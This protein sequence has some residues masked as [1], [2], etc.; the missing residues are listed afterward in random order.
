MAG[1]HWILPLSTHLKPMYANSR[2]ITR[3]ALLTRSARAAAFAAVASPFAP[4]FAS[5]QS[6]RFKIGACD[7]AMGNRSDPAAFDLAKQIGLDGVQVDMGTI[8][9]GMR[10]RQPEVQRTYL[11]T[12]KRTGIEIAS[13]AIAENWSAPLA[14][15]P[16][17]A[18][19][20]ADS[21]DVCKALGLTITM[22]ACFEVDLNKTAEVDHFVGVIKEI[23]P[24]A[25]KQGVVIGLENWLSA[26]D[27]QR[28]LERIGSPA[29]KVYYD[30]GNSTDKGRDVLKEIRALGKLICELHAKDGSHLLGQG[31]IDFKQV[32]K[33][34]DDI[35][36]SGWIHLESAAPNG[37]IRDYTAQQKY[38]R[39]LF[40]R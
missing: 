10:L 20:L 39:E 17:A 7:W 12:A 36:Y 26:E 1:D 2:R 24:K 27:H 33:A 28:I 5:P 38:L 15:D 31:R 18:R 14:T 3:R 6:R 34:L 21:I 35:Q 30:V 11:E 40:P 29:V 37:L 13:L 25:E 4:L 16:R 23:A 9:N 32:R 22:P 19:W 8:A